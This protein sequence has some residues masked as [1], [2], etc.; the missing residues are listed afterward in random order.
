MLH[1]PV[2]A[3]TWVTALHGEGLSPATVHHHYVALKKAFRYAQHDRLIAFN[4]CDGVKLPK[5]ATV[6]DFAP[7][8]L[9]AAEVE[10]VAARLDATAAPYGL[11]VRFAAFTGLRA[12][13]LTGLR[14]RDLNLTAGHV[15]VRQTLARIG[16]EWK[17]STP[18]SAR[19]SRNVP[20]VERSLVRDLRAYL[21]AHPN[22]GDPDALLWPGRVSGSHLVTF[23]RVLDTGSVLRNYLRP[24]VD[25]RGATADAAPRPPPH[26]RPLMLAAGFPP[27]EVSRWLGHAN[28]ATTDAIYAH[29]YPSDYSGHVDRF[30]AFVAEAR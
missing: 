10:R 22:S 6:N 3:G 23:D 8:F 18:K 2:S 17:V 27:Y 21:V 5:A 14:M 13:E 25:S 11:L 24:A 15:E 19:S 16:G 7:R 12:A 29:L 28:L 26:L 1:A 9:T 4:P 20:L 30:S